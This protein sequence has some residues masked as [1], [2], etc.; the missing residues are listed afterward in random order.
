M[1]WGEQ[2]VLQLKDMAAV[3]ALHHF[4]MSMPI[5]WSTFYMEL[6]AKYIPSNPF[7]LAKHEWKE[8]SLKKG[9]HIIELNKHFIRLC[10]KWD[11]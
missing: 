9:E 8:P 5:E 7:N 4:P 11:P 10:S 3:W 1:G 2:P 6:N